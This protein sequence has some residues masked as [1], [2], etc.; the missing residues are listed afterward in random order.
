MSED[1]NRN[2]VLRQLAALQE[3]STEELKEKWR[4]LYGSD[5]PRFKKSFIQKRLA[6]RIQ[7]LFYGG[8]SSQAEK[9]LSEAARSDPLC[10]LG[11]KSSVVM[12]TFRRTGRIAPGTRFVREWN[13]NRYEV[14]VRAEGF[15][16][17]GKIY[18]SLSAIASEITGTRWNGRVFFGLKTRSG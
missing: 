18:R 1:R 4:D 15:E 7:E 9:K 2:S 14:I 13:D 10:T 17:N 6:Y 16:Y 5:P 11:K 12:S 8:I 3:M